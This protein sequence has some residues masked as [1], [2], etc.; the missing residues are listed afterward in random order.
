MAVVIQPYNPWRE[1]L[2]ANILMP[3]VSDLW[4][5]HRENELNRKRNTLRGRA[6]KEIAA[7]GGA[8]NQSGGMT[9]GL[10]TSG[11]LGTNSGN[12]MAEF[13][14]NTGSTAGVADLAA[15]AARGL[16]IQETGAGSQPYMPTAT[17][18]RNTIGR[19]AADKRFSHLS[20]QGIDELFAPNIQAAEAARLEAR[21]NE[22]AQNYIN[23]MNA[24]NLFGARNGVMGGVIGGYIPES[25][26]N[27]VNAQFGQDRPQTS[28]LNT[29]G[30]NRAIR[31]NPVT[32]DVEEVARFENTLTPAQVQ[33]GEQWD[34][35][36]E[37]TK[38]TDQRN[39]EANR[40]DARNNYNLQKQPKLTNVTRL[41]DGRRIGTFSD[42][43]EK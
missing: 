9:G 33:A 18:W 3:I 15:Q 37:W 7:M 5:T 6:I 43:T 14:A 42:G 1:Q 41:D 22:A 19:L 4:K 30:E 17:D 31:V 36:F 34:K 28:M 12:P 29:G 2:A 20:P 11:A 35:Q 8:S 16:G 27:M 13:D 26:G 24:G 10:G 32:G 38:A 21:R 39:F 40:E 23:A 25:T